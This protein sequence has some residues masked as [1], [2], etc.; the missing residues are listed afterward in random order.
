MRIDSECKLAD[1]V[2]LLELNCEVEEGRLCRKCNKN[3]SDT[4]EG[5]IFCNQCTDELN[6]NLKAIDEVK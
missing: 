6:N 2:E 5:Y 4:P 1:F 3:I